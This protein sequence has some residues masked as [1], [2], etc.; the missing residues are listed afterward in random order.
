VGVELQILHHEP[1][2]PLELQ[3]RRHPDQGDPFGGVNRQLHRLRPARPPAARGITRRRRRGLGTRL[4][5]RFQGVRLQLRTRRTALQAPYL[6]RQPLN[7]LLL[8]GND[9][10]QTA[11]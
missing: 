11:D 5:G 1:P 10:Q 9:L 2:I 7:L 3:P 6:I 8:F 4:A